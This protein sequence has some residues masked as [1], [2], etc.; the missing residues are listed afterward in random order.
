MKQFGG[1]EVREVTLLVL[2][3]GRQNDGYYKNNSGLRTM[4]GGLTIKYFQT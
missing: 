3:G 1:K 4:D 2:E